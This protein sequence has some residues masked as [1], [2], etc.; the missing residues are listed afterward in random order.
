M[1]HSVRTTTTESF[2]TPT[3]TKSAM[4]QSSNLGAGMRME[5]H[6]RRCAV[7]LRCSGPL[8]SG[9]MGDI[10]SQLGAGKEPLADLWCLGMPH[11]M[12][13]RP[14]PLRNEQRPTEPKFWGIPSL[15][16]F[17]ICGVQFGCDKR[18]LKCIN[19]GWISKINLTNKSASFGTD[20]PTYSVMKKPLLS[21]VTLFLLLCCLLHFLFYCLSSIMDLKAFCPESASV[22]LIRL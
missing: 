11:K 14:C 2:P 9:T 3:T 8:D 17:S 4:S 6:Y 1:T 13:E 16:F 21:M 5:S 12:G 19:S 22:P 18:F 20:S 15:H 10:S 7:L